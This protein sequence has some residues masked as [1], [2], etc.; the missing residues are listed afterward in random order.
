MECNPAPS[1]KQPS[2]LWF[3]M[4]F[5]KVKLS[6]NKFIF[7]FA[8]ALACLAGSAD[9]SFAL[10]PKP[11]LDRG[12][13]RSGYTNGESLYHRG[14]R[15][16]QVVIFPKSNAPHRNF[17]A[18]RDTSFVPYA[19]E[20]ELYSVTVYPGRNIVCFSH[21]FYSKVGSLLDENYPGLSKEVPI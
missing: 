20:T 4:G 2:A 14:I 11:F 1:L 21:L 15:G 13:L 7:L 5:G 10:R 16:V 9:L 18:I 12:T 3:S 6:P 8:A 17:D 19:K